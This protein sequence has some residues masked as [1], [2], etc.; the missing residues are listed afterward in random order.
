MS[1]IAL[2]PT[3]ELMLD[4]TDEQ[5]WQL[6]E[7][8]R[9]LR[10]ERA[11][12]GELIIMPPT[13]SETGRRNMDLSF[14]LQSWS[15]QNG[16]GIAFDSSTGFKLP[17]EANRSPDAA[18]I[19]KERWEALTAEQQEKF[20]PICPDF[21]VELRSPSDNLENLQ[22]KMRE[23][24]ANGARLGWLL[25]RQNREVEIYRP[26]REVE[27]KRSPTTLSREDVLPGFILSLEQIL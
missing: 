14:Q 12:T 20:A 10:F 26:N 19:K 15:R 4:L 5:F 25:N 17:N 22:K 7:N 23:Y 11:A 24:I 3:L 16:L 27:I 6:C 13:G 18:W 1:A 9:D 2:P 8:N 21:V